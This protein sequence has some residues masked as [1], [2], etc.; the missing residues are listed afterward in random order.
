LFG[1]KN[2]LDLLFVEN[3]GHNLIRLSLGIVSV[4]R[5][6]NRVAEQTTEMG[7]DAIRL[8]TAVNTGLPSEPQTVTMWSVSGAAGGVG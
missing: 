2:G 6:F 3:A 7:F 5:K 4:L 8:V 1:N